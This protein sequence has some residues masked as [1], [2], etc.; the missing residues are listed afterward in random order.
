MLFIFSNPWS[1]LHLQ[2]LVP[3][4]HADGSSK[5]DNLAIF[6]GK[7][8]VAGLA[9]RSVTRNTA[10]LKDLWKFSAL[11]IRFL[12]IAIWQQLR[13]AWVMVS[14]V[15]S[16]FAVQISWLLPLGSK[17]CDAQAC[18]S[19][20][21]GLLASRALEDCI[22][23]QLCSNGTIV[24]QPQPI[25]SWPAIFLCETTICDL[26]W[27]PCL[28]VLIELLLLKLTLWLAGEEKL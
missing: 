28:F 5:S 8:I 1:V 13:L 18:P 6:R 23:L 24:H 19:F 22:Q 3:D 9:G 26:N 21:G 25:S 7:T 11:T 16:I 15:A 17:Y 12:A 4:Y 2:R 27:T 20:L 10:S 14:S